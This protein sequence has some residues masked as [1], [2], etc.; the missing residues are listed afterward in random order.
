[1]ANGSWKFVQKAPRSN[2]YEHPSA[3]AHSNSGY[4]WRRFTQPTISFVGG[5]THPN[6]GRIKTTKFA[7]KYFRA[8]Q[9]AQRRINSKKGA[10]SSTSKGFVSLKKKGLKAYKD[11]NKI[12]KFGVLY[13]LEA[14]NVITPKRC[15]Y[16][17][18]GTMPYRLVVNHVWRAILKALVS[19]TGVAIQDFLDVMT[20]DYSVGTS[21]TTRFRYNYDPN[22]QTPS[23]YTL[24]GGETYEYVALELAKLFDDKGPDFQII[25]IELLEESQTGGSTK[26]EEINLVDSKLVFD[27]KSSLKIQNRSKNS[28]G[29]EADEV[30]NVPL[31]GKSYESSSQALRYFH[32]PT[33]T[34]KRFAVNKKNGLMDLTVDSNGVG[35]GMFAEPPPPKLFVGI[36]KCGKIHLDPSQIQTSVLT[37]KFTISMDNFIAKIVGVDANDSTG[38]VK[39]RRELGKCRVFGLEKM[40]EVNTGSEQTIVEMNIAYEHDYKLGVMLKYKNPV[41]TTVVIQDTLGST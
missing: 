38:V 10:L 8:V 11:V 15:G 27:V 31:Y 17:G 24:A 22:N 12:A 26:R 6:M 20:N 21:I 3:G 16:V 18:H 5:R 14:G 9:K 4:G 23:T 32:E 30:D 7:G 2:I 40:L 19:K 34:Y 35:E 39:V 29:S 37:E 13:R 36:T 41:R 33:G 1:M 28:L 25:S